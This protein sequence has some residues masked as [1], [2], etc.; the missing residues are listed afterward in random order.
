VTLRQEL[1][2][3]VGADPANL[4]VTGQSLVAIHGWTFL[5]GPGV[6]PAVN[7]L[8]LG[9]ILYRSRLVP[10]GDPHTG[11]HRRPVLLASATAV[12]FGIYD[13][14]STPSATAAL[15]IA[16]WEGSLGVWLIAKGFTSAP[17]PHPDRPSGLAALAAP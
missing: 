15:P 2:G 9:Y 5:L 1:A 11:T 12:M 14:V 3:T 17:R 10:T 13:Q 4:V 7:A 8:C 6:I 16:V